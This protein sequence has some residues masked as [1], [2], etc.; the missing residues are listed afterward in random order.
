MARTDSWHCLAAG[1]YAD[2]TGALHLVVEDMLAASGYPDTPE[3]R[4]TL[5]DAA[6]AVFGGEGIPVYEVDDA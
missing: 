3:N 4:A 5:I 2:D 6:R 1:V